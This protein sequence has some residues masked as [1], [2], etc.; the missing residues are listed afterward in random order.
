MKKNEIKEVMNPTRPI[1]S[2]LKEAFNGENF[3]PEIK[4]D[5]IEHEQYMK[6]F[7]ARAL[8][9]PCYKDHASML[10]FL[11]N[12]IDPVLKDVEDVDRY[13]NVLEKTLSNQ[14]DSARGF[15]AELV[16]A[17]RAHKAGFKIL[18]LDKYAYS[19]SGQRT[20]IDLYVE[21]PGGKRAI[22]ENKDVR[23][24]IALDKST[25]RKMGLFSHDLYDKNGELVK[26][27][28]AVFINSKGIS[29][30][31]LDYANDKDLHVKENMD[32][33][34]RERYYKNLIAKLDSE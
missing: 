21:T 23:S 30:N 19:K 14:R 24:G 13:H 27:D 28:A 15:F 25:K 18:A 29:K 32:G 17:Y 16:N 8:E 1:E 26:K 11:K 4:K 9:R 2:S 20:D 22:I 10:R 6:Q 3:T 34:A 5:I 12:N 7:E 31:A 33:R